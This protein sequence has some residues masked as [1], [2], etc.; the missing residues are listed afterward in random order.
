MVAGKLK[1]V[2]LELA[3]MQHMKGLSEDTVTSIAETM[4]FVSASCVWNKNCSWALDPC[5][6]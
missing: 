1:Q 5:T 6:N 2:E 4:E 3:R